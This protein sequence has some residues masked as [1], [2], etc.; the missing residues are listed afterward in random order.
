MLD[1]A[2]IYLLSDTGIRSPWLTDTQ[3]QRILL[4]RSIWFHLL[5]FQIWTLLYPAALL[6]A[7]RL[8]LS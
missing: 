3:F 6:T 4:V 5:C 8:P 7:C 1:P 2:D